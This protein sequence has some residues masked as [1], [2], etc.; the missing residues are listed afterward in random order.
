MEEMIVVMLQ[1]TELKHTIYIMSN[2]SEIIH[3]IIKCTQEE[4]LS[5]VA[6]SA[7]KYK[8]DLIKLQGPQD[9]TL[10]IKNQ[11][12]TKINTCFG[13]DNKITIELIK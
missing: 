5:T 3:I 8:I 4:L 7:S 12:S 2:N 9:Y 10:G 13:K 11:L 1:P 6:M